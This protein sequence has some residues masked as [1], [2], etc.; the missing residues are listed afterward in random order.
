MLR[1]ALRVLALVVIAA[2]YVILAGGAIASEQAEPAPASL[3]RAQTAAVSD[4]ARRGGDSVCGIPIPAE[5]G[6]AVASGDT[7]F[8]FVSTDSAVPQALCLQ[9]LGYLDAIGVQ[10]VRRYE[11]EMRWPWWLKVLFSVGL[12]A[13]VGFSGYL[14]FRP[15]SVGARPE[16]L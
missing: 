7:V 11:N 6:E 8:A 5:L 2:L 10:A 3:S 15:R 4:A 9:R 14:L 16:S 1:V 13:V 12:I